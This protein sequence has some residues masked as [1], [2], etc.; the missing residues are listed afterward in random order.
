MTRDEIRSA[1]LKCLLGVAP[2]AGSM[3]LRADQQ[4]REQ[5]E[6]DSFDFLKFII[7]LDKSV[8]VSIPESDY[9]KLGT[10]DSCVD[11]LAARLDAAA[12]GREA[13]R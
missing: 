4:I 11:Y 10:I 12:A 9:P 7:A 3:D 13:T 1:V 2:E 5:I 8:S 6:I